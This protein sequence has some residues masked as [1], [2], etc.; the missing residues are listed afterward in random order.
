MKILDA[1][2]EPDPDKQLS[3]TQFYQAFN[4]ILDHALKEQGA[5]GAG[6]AVMACID[7][8][9]AAVG[10]FG[11]KKDTLAIREII[12]YFNTFSNII[13][14]IGE[15]DAVDEFN[16][17]IYGSG[18]QSPDAVQAEKARLSRKFLP[19]LYA[20]SED[21]SPPAG[22]P[23]YNVGQ[24]EGYSGVKVIG[25]H[26]PWWG[27]SEELQR[28]RKQ[29]AEILAC[30]R[31]TRFVRA[32]EI[33]DRFR[34]N[35]ADVF[36]DRDA[37]RALAWEAV[38]EPPDFNFTIEEP[39]SLAFLLGEP[40]VFC[41]HNVLTFGRRHQILNTI[42]LRRAMSEGAQYSVKPGPWGEQFLK[43]HERTYDKYY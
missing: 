12:G 11:W 1:P 19:R 4:D 34:L 18:I 10:A 22:W 17:L 41:G 42:K 40:A 23:A 37:M 21:V 7:L 39:S 15:F 38:N 30:P 9:R 32:K 20:S 13:V 31:E 5:P 6:E 14:K 16:I 26:K 27:R 24:M 28:F 29:M 43:I 3:L 35:H 25:P 33:T 8:C 36:Q 2:I